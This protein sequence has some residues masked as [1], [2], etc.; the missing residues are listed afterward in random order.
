ML[1]GRVV[2]DQIGDDPDAPRMRGPGQ[3]LEV[4]DGADGGMDAAEVGD[5]VAVV[6]QRREIN[7]HEPEAIDAEVLQ[8]IELRGQSGEVAVAVLVRVVESANVDLVEDGILVPELI[9]S[10]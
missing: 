3:D 6:L 7:R 2:D 10:E 5:V 1:V 8:V 4:F 9:L